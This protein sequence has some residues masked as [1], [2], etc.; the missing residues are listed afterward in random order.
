MIYK[1]QCKENKWYQHTSKN[2]WEFR[3][4]S[5]WYNCLQDSDCAKHLIILKQSQ[6]ETWDYDLWF[7]LSLAILYS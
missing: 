6:N 1:L 3:V 5:D 7:Y 2:D 4:S